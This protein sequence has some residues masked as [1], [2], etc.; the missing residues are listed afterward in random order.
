MKCVVFS[1]IILAA[2]S[3]YA[4]TTESFGHLKLEKRQ[5]TTTM[6]VTSVNF[7]RNESTITA[8]AD[9]EAYG[10]VYGTFRLAYNQD[11][12]GGSVHC[13]GRGFWNEG[14]VSGEGNGYWDLVDSVVTIRFISVIS[15]GMVSFEVAKFIPRTREMTLEIY[16]IK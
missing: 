6:T 10:L 9:M 3:P 11:R 1:I 13:E 5:P 15:N 7:G 4:Q 8:E 16:E 14:M 12:Q 2:S